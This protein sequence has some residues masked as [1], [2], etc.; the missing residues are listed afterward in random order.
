MHRRLD[1]FQNLRFDRVSAIQILSSVGQNE[2]HKVIDSAQPYFPGTV[3]S[4]S[5]VPSYIPSLVQ[6]SLPD[7]AEEDND[8]RIVLTLSAATIDGL[9]EYNFAPSVMHD[10]VELLQ[11][12]FLMNQ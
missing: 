5:F 11:Q 3:P 12:D 1:L 10:A 4:E 6:H 7:P 8:Q 2:I 9:N